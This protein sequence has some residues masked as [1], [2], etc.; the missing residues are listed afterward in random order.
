MDMEKPGQPML[1]GMD[2]Y[3]AL[4]KSEKYISGTLAALP[5][6]RKA[7]ASKGFSGPAFVGINNV[8]EVRGGL[9]G[10]PGD[11]DRCPVGWTD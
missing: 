4:L 3:I 2:W 8:G 11:E 9:E 10:D 6:L 5:A 1:P 7:V